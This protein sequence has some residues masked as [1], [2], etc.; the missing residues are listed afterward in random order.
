MSKEIAT[1]KIN[2]KGDKEALEFYE[3]IKKMLDETSLKYF[4]IEVQTHA[5][6][7]FVFRNKLD[8]STL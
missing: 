5:V 8:K 4:D 2:I 6:G 1:I 7:H 3:K